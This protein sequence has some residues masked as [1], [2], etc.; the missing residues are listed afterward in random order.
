MW[1]GENVPEPPVLSCTLKLEVPEPVQ[2]IDIVP[3]IATWDPV[4]A[5]NATPVEESVHVAVR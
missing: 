4:N 3:L 5:P 1:R 2:C